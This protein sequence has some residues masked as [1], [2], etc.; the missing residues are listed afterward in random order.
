MTSALQY[1]LSA[2][3]LSGGTDLN[4]GYVVTGTKGGSF[5]FGS[6]EDFNFQLGR[7]INGV[8]DILTIAVLTDTA[9]ADVGCLS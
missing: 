2:T 1:D 5:N 7:T 4:S 6:L 3:S 9:G 8:S